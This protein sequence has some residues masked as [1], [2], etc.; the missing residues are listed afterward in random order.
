MKRVAPCVGYETPSS[1][2]MTNRTPIGILPPLLGAS[3]CTDP[4]LN[5][6]FLPP[7]T[8]TEPGGVM[9]SAPAALG[10]SHSSRDD[11]ARPQRTERLPPLP[12]PPDTQKSVCTVSPL[13][14]ALAWTVKPLPTFHASSWSTLSPPRRRIRASICP[15][16][17]MS[18]SLSTT[19]PCDSDMRGP[20]AGR[21]AALR[22]WK[23]GVDASAEAV[24]SWGVSARASTV[25]ERA[26]RAACACAPLPGILVEGP[27]QRREPLRVRRS[28]AAAVQ[29]N[30]HQQER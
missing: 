15:A 28:V 1:I 18:C 6:V 14:S 13:C 21:S 30:K 20:W 22:G 2:S 26:R 8:S 24:G 16:S 23:E 11:M 4:S 29:G 10:W 5:L 25:A 3:K 27:E 9:C 7:G 17:L 19:L 12:S